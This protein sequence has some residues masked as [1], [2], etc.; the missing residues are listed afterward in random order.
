MLTVHDHRGGGR[1]V[2]RRAV[3][4]RLLLRR[5]RLGRLLRFPRPLAL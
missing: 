5:R 4:R 3:G 1:P 2:Q